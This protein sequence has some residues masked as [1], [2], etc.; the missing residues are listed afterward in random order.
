VDKDDRLIYVKPAEVKRCVLLED[1]TGQRCVNCPDATNEINKLQQQYG[2]DNVIAVAIHGGNFGIYNSTPTVT[3]LSTEE[4]REYYTKW[5]IEAQ[6]AGIV[7]RHGGVSN[8]TTWATSIYNELQEP[9]P[10]SITL[11]TAF[12]DSSRSLQVKTG[13]LSGEKLNGKLQL[14]LTEDN[15]TALQLMPNGS[16]NPEYLH[17]HVFR[18]SINGTWGTDIT[19]G[20]SQVEATFTT[21]IDSG[22]LPELMSVVAFVYNEEGVLQV[23][24]QKIKD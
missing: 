2:E 18:K 12:D 4:A 1:F 23:T 3:A 20:E 11:N 13:I 8:Y 5:N 16:P 7:N 9:S 10:V 6:P 17:N 15:I 22:W 14:W 24:K 21:T 19:L